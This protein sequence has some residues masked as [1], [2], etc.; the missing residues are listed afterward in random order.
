MDITA[1]FDT[2]DHELL[3]QTLERGFGIKGLALT[4]LRSYLTGRIFR[5]EYADMTSTTMNV[6][7]SVQQK[8]VLGPLLSISYTADLSRN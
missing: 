4:W 2:I 8:S 3:L 1:A 6:A 7:C 5:V